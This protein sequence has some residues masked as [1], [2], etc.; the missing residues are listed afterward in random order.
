VKR[1]EKETENVT[2]LADRRPFHGIGSR[3][4]LAQS[5]AI[6]RHGH[7]RSS[8]I[9]KGGIFNAALRL[10]VQSRHLDRQRGERSELDIRAFRCLAGLFTTTKISTNVPSADG[11]TWNRV[12]VDGRLLSNAVEP[13]PSQQAVWCT[14]ERVLA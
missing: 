6:S 8:L 14:D 5:T 1:T 13:S 3:L 11:R 10:G 7:R 9:G 12:C 2:L 4:A